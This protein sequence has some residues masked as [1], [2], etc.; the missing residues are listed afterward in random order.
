MSNDLL[1]SSFDSITIGALQ[2]IGFK[3]IPPKDAGIGDFVAMSGA[4]KDIAW[5]AKDIDQQGLLVTVGGNIDRRSQYR[6]FRPIERRFRHSK[7]KQNMFAIKTD[8]N[9]SLL[10]TTAEA[11]DTRKPLPVNGSGFY[12]EELANTKSLK[13]NDGRD[14]CF[15]CGGQTQTVPL[16]TSNIQI[17]PRC[18]V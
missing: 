15:Q 16:F 6:Y 17:C 14:T 2:V 18:K 13:N 9:F 12:I 10:A 3:Y 4:M 11:T 8:S 1:V 7:S 5:R